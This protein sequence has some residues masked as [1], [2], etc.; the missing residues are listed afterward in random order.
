[1]QSECLN[2][3][4]SE[5]IVIWRPIVLISKVLKRTLCPPLAVLFFDSF[6][7]SLD[8]QSMNTISMRVLILT[9]KACLWLIM[10]Y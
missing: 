9:L 8:V 6:F 5:N 10:S 1:M 2:I 7:N 3:Q 4:K